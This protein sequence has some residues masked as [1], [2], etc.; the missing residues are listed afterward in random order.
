MKAELP[1]VKK[2]DVKVTVEEG[3]LRIS[4]ERK[5]EQGEK[6]KKWHRIER[7]SGLFLRAFALPAGADGTK[8]AADYKDGVL[9][10][11][12]PKTAEAKPKAIEVK[13]A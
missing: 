10:V 9:T 1:E 8:V 12:L 3:V 4:G 13:V 11:H 7:S 6:N 5:F 2:E